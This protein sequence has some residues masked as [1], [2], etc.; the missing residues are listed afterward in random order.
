MLLYKRVAP[1][2]KSKIGGGSIIE[3]SSN[4]M[5]ESL[6]QYGVSSPK[7]GWPPRHDRA[8]QNIFLEILRESQ[9]ARTCFARLWPA[10]ETNHRRHITLGDPSREEMDM[11]DRV[12]SHQIVSVLAAVPGCHRLAVSRNLGWILICKRCPSQELIADMLN[13]R[14]AG[15]LGCSYSRVVRKWLTICAKRLSRDPTLAFV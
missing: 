6:C 13:S 4:T 1:W 15:I 14:S 7:H 8:E 3:I 12:V 5:Q 10:G 11:V 2:S 9:A